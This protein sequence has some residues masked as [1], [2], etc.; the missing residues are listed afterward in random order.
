VD[1]PLKNLDGRRELAED[2]PGQSSLTLA[3]C[4]PLRVSRK[5]EF[6]PAFSMSSFFCIQK[7]KKQNKTVED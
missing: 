7:N 2:H 1:L 5:P 3:A 6:L 4:L